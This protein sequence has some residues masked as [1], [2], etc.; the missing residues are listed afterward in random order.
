MIAYLRWR[1]GKFAMVDVP[2][3]TTFVMVPFIVGGY[4]GQVVFRCHMIIESIGAAFY[5][6]SEDRLD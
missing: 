5:T 6:E 2:N 4:L 1:D 3:F